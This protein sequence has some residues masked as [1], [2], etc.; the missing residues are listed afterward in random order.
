MQGKM[1]I[2]GSLT[3][4]LLMIAGCALRSPTP[5]SVEPVRPL[6][7]GDW[8]E[9]KEQIWTASALAQSEA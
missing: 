2:A 5:D 6:S 3:A 8:A 4:L 9:I 1:L 7:V